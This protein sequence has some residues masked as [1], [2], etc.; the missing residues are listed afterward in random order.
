MCLTDFGFEGFFSQIFAK[1]GKMNAIVE[2]DREHTQ[3]E[4]GGCSGISLVKFASQI[5]QEQIMF[6]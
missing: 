3:I 4:N 2:V 1:D 5:E 6:L